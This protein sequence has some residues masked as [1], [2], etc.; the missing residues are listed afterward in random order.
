[1]TF[2]ELLLV[3]VT[4]LLLMQGVLDIVQAIRGRDSL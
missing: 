1:M 3:I 4:G 2:L